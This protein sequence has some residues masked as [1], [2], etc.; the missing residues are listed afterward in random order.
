M[1]WRNKLKTEISAIISTVV[2]CEYSTDSN[3]INKN[4]ADIFGL[5]L[6]L[7]H[8]FTNQPL[9]K[10][11]FEFQL[12]STFNLTERPCEVIE[13][14]T[15]PGADLFLTQEKTK[16]SLKTEG[17]KSIKS[18]SITISKLM[19][20]RWYRDCTNED[21]LFKMI[22]QKVCPHLE[23]Y[24]R[25]FTLRSFPDYSNRTV[26][27]DLVEIY[28][29]L[30]LLLSDRKNLEFSART[31]GGSVTVS[32]KD[33]IERAFSLVFD[34]SVEK[35]TLQNLPTHRCFQHASWNVPLQ[36]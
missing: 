9:T 18:E 36:V 1:D 29:N 13:N 26:R 34:A 24:D 3:I 12:C 28:K 21:L 33:G 4:S 31:K 27:Y 15:L 32:V 10:K 17:A 14:S 20:A 11:A 23:E 25:I 8:H 22:L 5:R 16:I 30:L 6:L 2:E 19:E 35:V 7:F